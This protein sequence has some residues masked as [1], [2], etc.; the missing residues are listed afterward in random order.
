[1][2]REQTNRWLSRWR[3][4]VDWEPGISRCKLLY[5]RWKEFPSWLSSNKAK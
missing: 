4:W 3:G 5:R 1:M 2:D